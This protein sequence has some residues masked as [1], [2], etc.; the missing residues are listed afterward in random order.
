MGLSLG[1]RTL[2][3]WPHFR[4]AQPMMLGLDTSSPAQVPC[5]G[6]PALLRRSHLRM[7]PCGL[8]CEMGPVFWSHQG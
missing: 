6:T 3:A 2:T 5:S 1:K 4:G 7:A 8:M